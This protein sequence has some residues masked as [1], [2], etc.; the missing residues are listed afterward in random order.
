M[1]DDALLML[2]RAG[3][4][5]FFEGPHALRWRPGR[6][7]LAELLLYLDDP[8]A[9]W[10]L[11]ATWMR[12]VLDADRVDGG[13]GGYLGP[14][15]RACDYVVLAEAQRPSLALPGVVGQVFDARDPGLRAVW[16]VPALLPIDEVGASAAMTEHLRGRL[17][18]AG[19]S[20]KLALPMRD[21]TRPVGLLCADWHRPAPAWRADTCLELARL[22][23]EALGPLMAS[24]L[25]LH[26]AEPD[27]R[28]ADAEAHAIDHTEAG[29][30]GCDRASPMPCSVD[31]G[32]DPAAWQRLTPAE[33]RV[34][35]LVARGLS[36]KEV[37]RQLGRSTSTVDHQLRSIRHKLGAGSTARLVHL[38]NEAGR[39]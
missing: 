25:Q 32:P 4:R 9:C 28:P 20:A 15:G 14:G 23:R 22:A 36:Y 6:E 38:L 3:R 21:D 27:G 2:Q 5:R 11:T 12:D 13:Y 29:G 26:Q 1:N 16:Q 10:R 34:A 31:L 39:G 30:R 18:A 37:A 33:R 7:L 24:L 35:A 19:T 17:Q 8:A